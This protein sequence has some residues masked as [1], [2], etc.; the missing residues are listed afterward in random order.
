MQDWNKATFGF[1]L[2]DQQKW[3]L[4][5]WNDQVNQKAKPSLCFVK[6]HNMQAYSCKWGIAPRIF[7]L[8]T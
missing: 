7:H 1:D 3:Q 5:N 8:A 4:N 6:Q 2:R